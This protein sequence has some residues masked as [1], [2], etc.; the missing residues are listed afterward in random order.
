M[1]VGGMPALQK[2]SQHIV[3]VEALHS[4]CVPGLLQQLKLLH[5]LGL[6]GRVELKL[7]QMVAKVVHAYVV[8]L[9]LVGGLHALQSLHVLPKRICT[10]VLH[11]SE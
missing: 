3:K 6:R 1:R 8:L 7:S 5:H 11:S 9:A 2:L 10:L 4:L